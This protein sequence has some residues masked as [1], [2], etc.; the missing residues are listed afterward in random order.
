[1]KI[2]RILLQTFTGN[3]LAYART[4]IQRDNIIR[5][6]L[7][8]FCFLFFFKWAYI[9]IIPR[10]SS[11]ETVKSS[12]M[13]SPTL[14]SLIHWPT[15]LSKDILSSLLRQCSKSADTYARPKCIILST[16]L[17]D[18][19]YTLVLVPLFR[20]SLDNSSLSCFA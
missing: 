15:H 17:F 13:V 16:P 20:G 8:S 6:I 7:V 1:M 11:H 3:H 18:A 10:S 2:R 4:P 5:L 19:Q 14:R 12:A 9:K